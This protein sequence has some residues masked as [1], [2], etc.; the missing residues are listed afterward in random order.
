MY[1]IQLFSNDV[2]GSIRTIADESGDI[3]FCAK[4]IAVALG[5]TNPR[6]AVLDHCRWVT[7]RDIPHPQSPDKTIE[8]SFIPQGDV[9]RLTFGSKL[10]NAEKFTDWVADEVLP[11]IRKHGAYMT[12][13]TL[14]R[15]LNDPDLVIGLATQL[16]E[17]RAKVKAEKERNVF[18]QL[19]P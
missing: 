9:Y 2:F 1:E 11:S 19:H 17:E 3:L 5:Y 16:K 14:D 8:A 4:D 7:K 10:P 15:L 12:E 6:K 18:F 13:P